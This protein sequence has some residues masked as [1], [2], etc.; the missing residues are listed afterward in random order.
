[1]FLAVL[2]HRIEFLFHFY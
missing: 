1:M 2:R